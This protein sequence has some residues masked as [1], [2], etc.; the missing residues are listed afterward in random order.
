MVTT[1]K[2]KRRTEHDDRDLALGREPRH[3]RF[4]GGRAK[5]SEISGARRQAPFAPAVV[6]HQNVIAGFTDAEI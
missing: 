6:Y 3:A 1:P 5:S 4:L 2:K